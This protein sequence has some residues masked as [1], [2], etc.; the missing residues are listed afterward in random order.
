MEIRN[1]SGQF[2]D[3]VDILRG[4]IGIARQN[5]ALDHAGCNIGEQQCISGDHDCGKCNGPEGKAG[6]ASVQHP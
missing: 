2:D 6:A 5:P 1:G 3:R 4:H